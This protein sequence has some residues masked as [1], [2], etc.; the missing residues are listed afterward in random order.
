MFFQN[1]K[2]IGCENCIDYCQKDA[3]QLK[4]NPSIYTPPEMGGDL[5][6]KILNELLILENLYFLIIEK[7]IYIYIYIDIEP[8]F[9]IL[10]F[11]F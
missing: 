3:I 5:Y 2:C 4:N 11:L 1:E 10:H 7:I 8:F 6:Q 9:P